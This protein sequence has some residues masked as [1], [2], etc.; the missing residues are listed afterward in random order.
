[1]SKTSKGLQQRCL[2]KPMTALAG[3]H[4]CKWPELRQI[5]SECTRSHVEQLRQSLTW[6]FRI[7]VAALS[8]AKHL[9]FSTCRLPTCLNIP[10]SP[11]GGPGEPQRGPWQGCSRLLCSNSECEASALAP[12]LQ[13]NL[14]NKTWA[15]GSSK[16]GSPRV[17]FAA[18]VAQANR[19]LVYQRQR[20]CIVSL[21]WFA[22]NQEP[23][24]Q[25][26]N[27]AS[28]I[29]LGLLSSSSGPLS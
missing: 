14:G 13:E 17:V 16:P 20:S 26:K 4:C 15:R 19:V 23:R 18:L 28:G 25:T 8:K 3:A 22:Q 29:E 10:L 12:R 21:L 7:A 2:S 11:R 6:A 24:L 5:Q 9:H 1:M 27:E